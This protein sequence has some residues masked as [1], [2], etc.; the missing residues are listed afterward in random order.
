MH[1]A[2]PS[3]SRPGGMLR[4]SPDSVLAL[5]ERPVQISGSAL[6]DSSVGRA[7][8]FE[9]HE[10]VALAI[11]VL[12]LIDGTLTHNERAKTRI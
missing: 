7:H 10:A 5:H 9:G 3:L 2:P 8:I 12:G 1:L 6:L 4:G 11:D